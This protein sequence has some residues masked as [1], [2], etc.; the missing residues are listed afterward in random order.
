MIFISHRGN[1]LGP[2][3]QNENKIFYIE[4][5]IAKGYFVEV[6]IIDYNGIDLFTLGHDF[7]QETVSSKFLLRKEIIAHA[8]NLNCLIGLLKHKIHCFF[9]TNEKYI[10]TSKNL[11]WCY[12]GVEDSNNDR[13]IIVLPELFPEKP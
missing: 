11:I 6:D 3:P 9:H 8:K 2:Q 4:E 10:F 7:K 12:P 1:I 5:A 13:C